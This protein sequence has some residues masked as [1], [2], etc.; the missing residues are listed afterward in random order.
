MERLTMQA[1]PTPQ[2]NFRYAALA[3]EIQKKILIC[4][5][6]FFPYLYKKILTT[7]QKNNIAQLKFNG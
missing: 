7:D 4:D 3:D 2:G 1:N 6:Y 5:N